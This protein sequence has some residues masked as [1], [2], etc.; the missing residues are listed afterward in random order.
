[1]A[2]QKLRFVQTT[3]TEDEYG[4]PRG[5]ETVI[6]RCAALKNVDLQ[7]KLVGILLMVTVLEFFEC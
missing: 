1:M 7:F 3:M 4:F 5:N 6:R 2:G